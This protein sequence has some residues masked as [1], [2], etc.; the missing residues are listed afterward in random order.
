MHSDSQ[1]ERNK[2]PPNKLIFEKSPYLLQH[3]YNPVHWFP[4]GDE[5][6]EKARRENKPIFLSIGYST[7]HW[8]HVM[9]EESF[10]DSEVARLMNEVFVSIK[11]DREERPD[12]DS[13]Y[14]A[15]CQ[16]LTGS[17]G[18]PLTILMT[19]D[20][21]PFFAGTYFPKES[22][23]GRIG[24]LE[25]VPQIQEVWS[26]H[27]DEVVDSVNQIT[28]ALQKVSIDV[29]GKEINET[30]LKA[31]YIQLSQSF[32]EDYSGFSTAPK[33]PSSHSLYFL[34]RYWRRGN[35][36]RTLEI[37]ERTLQAMRYGGVY[38]HI[39]FG[40][41]RYATDREWLIPHFEKMLYD[42][43]MIAM[44]YIEAYQATKKEEF[45]NT[46]RE[47]FTY[48]LRDMT[49][50]DGG[51]YSAEDADSEGEEGK[52]YLW[53]EEEIKQS[54]SR[55]EAEFAI[56]IFNVEKDGNFSEE[57]T[58]HK[59]GKNI[60]HFSKSLKEIALALNREEQDVRRS[61]E[62]VRKKLFEVRE[63]RIHPYKDDKILTDWN[64]LMIVALAKGAQ[65]FDEQRYAEAAQC[66]GD[67]I[68]NTM[69]REDGR[70]LHRYRE[71]EAA[72]LANVNDYAF[73]IW[74]LIELYES[75]FEVR[76]LK[77][78]IDLSNDLIKHFWDE[79]EGGF[80]FTADDS[81]ELLIRWKD[82]Y[83]GALPSGNSV[84]VL[85]FIRLARMTGNPK[86]QETALQIVKTFS[87]RVLQSLISYTQ[88]M[89]AVDFLIGP[90]YEIVIVGDSKAD[91]TTVMLKA[92]REQFIPNKVVL[93]RPADVKLP[94][95][96][97]LTAFTSNLIGIEGKATAYVC[98]DY[99]CK[100][101]TIDR[102]D[103]LKLLNV[104]AQR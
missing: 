53:T 86:F 42:Q 49:A 62:E 43:A 19:P 50:P 5:A 77:N 36:K 104:P 80:Y 76:Y 54:L 69:Q 65:V 83:D 47:I 13:I 40:F 3:A 4:W 37:V 22:R 32:D 101:P 64:G 56:Q 35:N 29:S 58:G 44:A 78:A 21:K 1:K 91:D 14:M 8:C 18:W 70:L 63:K 66:A 51:F 27:Y 41:H 30:A 34:L 79:K 31:T 20:K 10:D 7:C 98:Q 85:N 74:G 59:I 103:M 72:V 11:A 95:I 39:G 9:E 2:R 71:G 102:E 55:E 87:R 23:Y 60:L 61:L 81:E 94:E 89:S 45:G 73:L 6:F 82:V 67:F 28:K 92:L 52:F 15:V 24:M 100:L 96:T 16:M 57:I 97:T 33:F 46:A 84:A 68:L 93:F 99:A 25:L 26:K 38:D 88:F 75:T 90:S 48:V 17:G 12:I